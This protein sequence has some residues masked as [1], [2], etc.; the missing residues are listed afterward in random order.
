M[1]E[2]VLCLALDPSPKE[3]EGIQI[4]EGEIQMRKQ[5]IQMEGVK[6]KKPVRRMSEPDWV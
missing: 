3:R 2:V 5:E 4:Q 1:G 6:S